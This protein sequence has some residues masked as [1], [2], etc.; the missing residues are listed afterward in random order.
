[1]KDKRTQDFVECGAIEECGPGSYSY[2]LHQKDV[3]PNEAKQFEKSTNRVNEHNIS[4][5]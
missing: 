2:S 4:N 1:M 3:E 5:M